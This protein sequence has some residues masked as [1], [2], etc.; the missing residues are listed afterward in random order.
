ML[1][2]PQTP[3]IVLVVVDILE[4][5]AGLRSFFDKSDNKEWLRGYEVTDIRRCKLC[6]ASAFKLEV[7]GK[8]GTY[9]WKAL[10]AQS[11]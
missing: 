8:P 1:W 3:A 9:E 10:L 2:R 6:D 11:T 4:E 7:V 5:G